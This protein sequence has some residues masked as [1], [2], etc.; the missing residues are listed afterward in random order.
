MIPRAGAKIVTPGNLRDDLLGRLHDRKQI[1]EAQFQAGRRFQADWG[2]QRRACAID[3]S[4]E[5]VDGGLVP[6]PIDEGADQGVGADQWCFAP[7]RG[8]WIDHRA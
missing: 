7:A 4:K 2:A 5:A 1:D 3:P 6:D 8:G